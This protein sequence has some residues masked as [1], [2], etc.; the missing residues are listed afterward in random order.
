M[1]ETRVVRGLAIGDVIQVDGFDDNMTVRSA[2]RIKKG[3]D[4]G[5]LE[6]AL[7][8]PDG[9]K[10]VMAFSPE[11]PVKVVGKDAEAG[12]AKSDGNAK[13]KGKGASAPK[14]KADSSKKRRQKKA[15]GK[16]KISALD[17]AAKRQA[18]R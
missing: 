3:L 18:K 10:E 8:A 13:G 11:E 5:K 9:E 2:K 14:P 6:V 17:A 16:K 15:K 1:S 12:T 7:V 4:A